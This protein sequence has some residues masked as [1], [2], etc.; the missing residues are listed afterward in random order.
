MVKV[1]NEDDGAPKSYLYK[2]VVFLTSILNW[3]K[4]AARE[5]F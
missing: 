2:N 4:S 5:G 3:S 1:E